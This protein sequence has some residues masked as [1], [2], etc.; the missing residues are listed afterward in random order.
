MSASRRMLLTIGLIMMW[1][2]SIL[3]IKL[4][5]TGFSPLTI[6]AMRVTVAAMCV[7]LL[8]YLRKGELPTSID[9]WLRASLM[10][11]FSSVLPFYLFCFAAQSIDSALVALLNGTIPM[12]TALFAR[13]FFPED[14][15]SFQKGFGI[16]LTLMGLIVVFAPYLTLDMTATYGGIFASLIAACSYAYGHIWGKKYLSSQKPFTAPAAQ[17]IMSS[18]FLIPVALFFDSPLSTSNPT[19]KAFS[20]VLGLAGLSTTCALLIYYKLLEHSCPTAVSAAACFLPI[21]G[22]LISVLFLD[23]V[24][25]PTIIIATLMILAGLFTVNEFFPINFG[26]KREDAPLSD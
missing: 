5:L 17:L 9:F 13:L 8:L 3:F 19:W 24:I 12:F 18:L 2:P 22:I 1:S 26:K 4:A 21:S 7:T 16:F 10:A 23:E 14:H 6:T 20:G 15:F 25:T 11:L